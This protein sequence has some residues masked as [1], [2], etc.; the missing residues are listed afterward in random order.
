MAGF[1]GFNVKY[2]EYEVITPQTKNSF[3]VRSLT[4]QEEEHLKGSLVTPTKV[5]DHLN[6]CLFDL[7]VKKP[8]KIKDFSSF[9]KSVTLKDRDALL[10]GLYHITYEEIRNYDIT[11]S[12]CQKDYSVS[13]KASDTFDI[14]PY[15]GKE[16]ILSKRTSVPLKL[17][18]GVTAIIKQPTLFDEVEALRELSSRPGSTIDVIT[19]ILIIDQFTQTGEA[20]KEPVIYDDRVDILDAY[21]S[22]PSK[23]KKLIFETY[24]EEFGKYAVSLKMRSF[25]QHCSN[26]EVITI[27]MVNNFFRALYGE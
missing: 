18:T 2:P 23:D 3:F 6:Q 22:L 26:E 24:K 13:T 9:L 16:P 14:L 17:T 21:L 4:V 19:D 25:C 12:A 27:N 10:Y 7:L 5:T 20:E 15:E 1:K 8:D 11:C